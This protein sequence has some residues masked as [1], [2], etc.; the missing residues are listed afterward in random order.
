MKRVYLDHAATTPVDERVQEAMLPYFGQVF[1]NPSSVH[2]Y[3]QR[4]DAALQE[5]R[6]SMAEHLGC[7]PEEL[8]FTSCGSESD[9]LALRGAALAAREQRGANR[10]LTTRVEHH[11]VLHTAQQMASLF[12]FEL[13][14]LPVDEYGQVQVEA[15][16]ERL[17]PDT[18]VVSVMHANNEVGTINPIKEIGQL[19]REQD[20]PFH[21]DAVQGAAHFPLQVQDLKVDLLSIGAH[22]F[23]G[24]KGIGALYIR[25]GTPLIPTQTGGSQ[26]YGKRAATENVALIVGMAAAFQQVYEQFDQ[27]SQH[28][29]SL[30][31]LIISEVQDRIPDAVL[32]GHPEERLPNHASFTFKGVDGNMLLSLLDVEGFA[33]SSGSACKTGNPEPSAVLQALGYDR[34]WSMG[35]LRVTVGKDTTED[36]VESFVDTLPVVVKKVRQLS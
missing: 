23:Y 30:R 11:A 27:R 26:E 16:A 19:C 29:Q 12:D 24:P 4:A 1:G 3:G 10:I 8:I 21:T 2:T 14:Y 31:N 7:S 15:V 22:K 33:C 6:R 34:E 13:S 20:I 18:A 28:A 17:Q 36:E 32:T 5:A 25:D 9:N 35:S